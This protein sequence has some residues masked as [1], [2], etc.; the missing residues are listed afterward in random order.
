M[1]E[2][3]LSKIRV[4]YDQIKIFFISSKIFWNIPLF[5][6]SAK[7]DRMRT[8]KIITFFSW[9][10][11]LTFAFFYGLT[12]N[13]EVKNY[14]N[15]SVLGQLWKVLR[16]EL[17]C[18]NMRVENKNELLFHMFYSKISDYFFTRLIILCLPTARYCMKSHYFFTSFFS[19][20]KI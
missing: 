16:N 1:F 2:F 15:L 5:S 18:I 4:N 7:H 19:S 10:I 13:D 3:E 11:F 8:E 14:F 9:I 17:Q 12:Q 6:N 20:S